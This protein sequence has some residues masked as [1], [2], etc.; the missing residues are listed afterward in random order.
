MQQPKTHNPGNVYR[1]GVGL[2]LVGL[3]LERP[4]IRK[5]IQLVCYIALLGC[6]S[7]MPV[8]AQTPQ[9]A[10]FF[11]SNGVKIR[12]VDK[13]EGEPVLLIHGF[14]SRLEFWEKIGIISGLTKNGFRA[15]AYDA[16]GHGASGKPHDP[17]QY[18]EEDVEDVL[19]LLDH[20][21]VDRAHV[22]GYSRGSMI[23]SRLVAQHPDRVRSVVFGGWAVGNPVSTLSSAKCQAVADSLS[24]GTYPVPLMRALIPEETPLPSAEEQAQFMKQIVEANDMVAVAAAFRSGCK[25][26]EITAAALRATGVPALAIVGAFDGMAPS[27]RAMGREMQD[28]VQVVVIPKADHITAARHPAFLKHLLSFLGEPK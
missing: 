28:G 16:R 26:R 17:E 9:D 4:L 12:Y 2:R 13:G 1:A 3:P 20:L 22:A 14:T 24:R 18:G 7:T 5:S 27:V 8:L 21:S 10:K 19:R 6:L 15:V 23:A 11:D 25:A